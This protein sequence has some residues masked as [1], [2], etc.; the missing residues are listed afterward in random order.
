MKINKNNIPPKSEWKK[1]S[2]KAGE[3]NDINLFNK[4]LIKKGY[5]IDEGKK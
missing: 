4:W 1:M 5:M 3:L 2:D